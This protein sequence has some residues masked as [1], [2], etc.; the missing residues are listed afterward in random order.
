MKE[1]N[2]I[3]DEELIALYRESGKSDIMDY[4]LNKYK[5]LVRKRANS[6]YLIGGDNEDLVQEGMIGLYKAIR[7]YDASREASFYTFAALCI[8][9]QTAKAIEAANRGK[10]Q[11]LNESISLDAES[12]SEGS[13]I[14]ENLLMQMA[15]P[16]TIYI[17]QESEAHLRASIS[18]KLSSYERKVLSLY[19]EGYTYVQIADELSKSAKSV[20]NAIQRIKGKVERQTWITNI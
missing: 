16:E 5:Q 17:D 14:Y 7:D 6:L 4:L 11:P 12:G 19:L 9:R 18:A 13:V 10:N 20:D 2:N 15:S 1:Y 8:N 3:S